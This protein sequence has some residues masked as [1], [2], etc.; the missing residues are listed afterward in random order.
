MDLHSL[1]KKRMGKK[2]NITFIRQRTWLTLLISI[3]I[4]MFSSF[5]RE[6]FFDE[7]EKGI[8]YLTYYPA[9]MIAAII[10]GLP[11]GFLATVLSSLL[12]SLW[13]QK[14]NLSTIEWWA[15]AFFIGVSVMISLLANAMRQA[16]VR[17]L[18]AQEQAEAANLAKSTFLANMSHELRTPLNAV[19]GFARNL[20]DQKTMPPENLRQID[21]IHRSG[22]HLLEMIDE[23]LNLSRIEAGREELQKAPFNLLR[24]IEDISRM[25]S[26]QVQAKKLRFDLK[27][28]SSLPR[29]VLGD[30]GKVRQILINL[31]GNAVKFTNKGYIGL[32]AWAIQY[33]DDP[34]IILLKLEVE[35]SGIGIPEE[36]LS[37][38]FDS[39]VQGGQNQTDV[40]GT[41][42]GLSITKSL[43]ELMGG[44]IEVKSKEG[45]GSLFEVSI[46]FEV[47][48]AGAISEDSSFS[49]VIGFGPGEKEWRI[50]VVD[51]IADNRAVLM[52]MLG[53]IGFKLKEAADGKAA[54]EI[55]KE[56]NPHLICTDM[57]MPVMDGHALTR[58]IRNLQRRDKVKILAVTASVFMKQRQEILDSGCDDMVSKPVKKEE[59]LEAIA[60]QLEIKYLY[61]EDLP[62]KNSETGVEL[63][64][65]MLAIL[66]MDLLEKLRYSAL[67]LDRVALSELCE[68][69]AV[70]APDAAKEFKVLI[71][72]FQFGKIQALLKDSE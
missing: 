44:H 3:V 55:F 67:L 50:L 22:E 47:A 21:I 48:E 19:L 36:Q 16:N 25:I 58:A 5:I 65:D 20:R 28:E 41:G 7:L 37:T 18:E 32:H 70:Y 26:V 49:R 17:A 72:N 54:L 11:S 68:Q 6:V 52:N 69:M 45:E 71:E 62:H 30:V 34:S 60:R 63:S 13:I 53:Q 33:K 29:A 24:S 14:G 2:M 64:R 8:P 39:F 42:L 35:D 51:D 38:I 10:G 56:W 27:L 40:Q 23:I 12:T 4:V 9:V 57:R 66:P 43:V 61:A 59:M 31:L 15:L 1:C 46:P